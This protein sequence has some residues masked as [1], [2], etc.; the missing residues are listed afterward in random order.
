MKKV[1]ATIIIM[2]AMLF[3]LTSCT[4]LPLTGMDIADP[5]TMEQLN[6]D[7]EYVSRGF[8]ESIFNDNEEMFNSCFPEGF[9][10]SINADSDTTVFEEYKSVLTIDGDFLGTMFEAYN[11]YTA[12]EGYDEDE[13]RLSISLITGIPEEDI[14]DLQIDKIKVYFRDDE[15]NAAQSIY[16]LV[17]SYQG[18]WYMYNVQNED[19]EFKN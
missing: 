16:F 2:S 19:A 6:T 12:E 10:E 7:G 14:G 11:N 4:K 1:I 18:S 13:M 9:I 8:I 15:G 5:V 3:S 17:Y